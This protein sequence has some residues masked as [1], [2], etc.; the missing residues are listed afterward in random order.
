[1]ERKLGFNFLFCCTSDRLQLPNRWN[2]HSFSTRAW[3]E[4]NDQLSSPH[5]WISQQYCIL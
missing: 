3:M 5:C 1:M 4:S 2:I